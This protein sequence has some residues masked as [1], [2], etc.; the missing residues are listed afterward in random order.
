MKKTVLI[1]LLLCLFGQVFGQKGRG[2]EVGVDIKDINLKKDFYYRYNK[3]IKK[4]TKVG[5]VKGSLHFKTITTDYKLIGRGQERSTTKTWAILDGISHQTMQRIADEFTVS[6]SKKIASLGISIK[7]WEAIKTSKA[8]AKLESK[9]IDKHKSNPT[10]GT[11]EIK[12]AN[13]GPHLRQATGNPG[14]ISACKKIAKDIDADGLTYDIIIDFARFDIQVSRW[15]SKG[16]GSGYDFVTTNT[17][18]SVLPQIGIKST[19]GAEGFGL[20][21]TNM[22]MINPNGLVSTISLNKTLFFPINFAK[23]VTSHEGKLPK[24]MKPFI[25]INT[26]HSGT[27]IIKADEAKYKKV[28]LEALDQ[29]T[30]KLLELIKTE[31]RK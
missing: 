1:T 21:S 16:Y 25:S 6:F 17:D 10:M 4:T 23:S 11:V 27:F 30:D 19:N 14:T 26:S 22:T 20:V 7:E 13:N 28:V 5:L 12:T 29:Y 31:I 15:K 8:Y 9:Q 24:G 3:V 18:A 2:G